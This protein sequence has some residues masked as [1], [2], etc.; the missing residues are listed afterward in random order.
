MSIA[1]QCRHCSRPLA[2]EV[3]EEL[4]WRVTS[5]QASPLLFE[6]DLDWNTFSGP[7]IIH[8]Y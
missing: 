7:N 8:D 3:D 5:P 6:P 2:L 1:S 4:R